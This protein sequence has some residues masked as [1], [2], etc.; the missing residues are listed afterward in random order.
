MHM[1]DE[2]ILAPLAAFVPDLLGLHGTDLVHVPQPYR[3]DPADPRD[4]DYI[5]QTRS[6]HEQ[7]NTVCGLCVA[8]YIIQRNILRVIK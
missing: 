5:V 4:E 6:K 1:G 7:V 2:R 3:S 8:F